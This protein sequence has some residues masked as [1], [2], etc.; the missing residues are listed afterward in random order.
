MTADP[1]TRTCA[2]GHRDLGPTLEG[3]V[4]GYCGREGEN[5]HPH[6]TPPLSRAAQTPGHLRVQHLV[7]SVLIMKNSI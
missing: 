2:P 4:L 5:G 1:E 7:E 3:A 6:M